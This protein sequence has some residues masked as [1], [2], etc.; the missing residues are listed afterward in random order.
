[1][2]PSEK[3]LQSSLETT[4]DQ[5]VEDYTSKEGPMKLKKRKSTLVAD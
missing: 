2:K 5:I 3:P 1:M 4:P